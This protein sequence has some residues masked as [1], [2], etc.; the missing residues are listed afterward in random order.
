MPNKLG[1]LTR[2]NGV[3]ALF[4]GVGVGGNRSPSAEILVPIACPREVLVGPI[5]VRV[6]FVLTGEL[7][8][9]VEWE[10]CARWFDDFVACLQCRNVTDVICG[11]VIHSAWGDGHEATNAFLVQEAFIFC[12]AVLDGG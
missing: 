2:P 4:F 5:G 1:K 3:S 6:W 8:T 11:F 10:I 7:V 12:R 9:Y